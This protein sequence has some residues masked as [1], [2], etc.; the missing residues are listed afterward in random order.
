MKRVLMYGALVALGL[1]ALSTSAVAKDHDRD[2]QRRDVRELRHEEHHHGRVEHRGHER[3]V[4]EHRK[5][6][7]NE[8]L[9]R[10]RRERER[11]EWA[12]HHHHQSTMGHHEGWERGRNNPHDHDGAV[13]HPSAVPATTAHA[14]RPPHSTYTNRPVRTAHMKPSADV[15]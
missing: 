9:A 5:H 10:E 2:H 3:H 6:E 4:A 12:R 11:R 8:H 13:N 1:V 14:T 7:G 15:R